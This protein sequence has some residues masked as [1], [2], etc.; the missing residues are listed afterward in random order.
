[1]RSIIFRISPPTRFGVVYRDELINS[2]TVTVLLHANALFL[3]ASPNGKETIA[4]SAS[5]LE[6]SSFR[7]QAGSYV[8]A[9]GGSRTRGCS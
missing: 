4:V 1:M 7:V 3:H 2:P 5:T 8:L 9:C 6:R